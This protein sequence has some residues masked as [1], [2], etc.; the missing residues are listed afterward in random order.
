MALFISKNF[1]GMSERELKDMHVHDG[2]P[3]VTTRTYDDIGGKYDLKKAAL[4][5]EILIELYDELDFP[6]NVILSLEYGKRIA[7]IGGMSP[8]IIDYLG[9][10][11]SE[12]IMADYQHVII[13]ARDAY[14]ERIG[15]NM[16]TGH[17]K[18]DQ[19][20]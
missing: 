20:P 15:I 3:E 13:T 8:D 16:I 2:A 6:F 7:K 4:L 19:K 10:T 17:S 11:P 5:Q 9:E 12:M 1:M 18:A 14:N